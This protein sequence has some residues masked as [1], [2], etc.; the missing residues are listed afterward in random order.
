M[1][2]EPAFAPTWAEYDRILDLVGQTGRCR[3]FQQAATASGFI[4]IRHDVECS[5]DKAAEMAEHEYAHGI[6][7]TYCIQLASETYNPAT[8]HNKRIIYQ[9]ARQGHQIALHHRQQAQTP[10]QELEA[11]KTALRALSAIAGTTVNVYSFHQPKADTPYHELIIPGAI[12]T[13]AQPYFK[14]FGTDGPDVLYISDSRRQWNYGC[15]DAKTLAAHKRIQ[16]LIHP[17]GWSTDGTDTVPG[18][19]AAAQA[20]YTAELVETVPT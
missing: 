11:L 4:V 5:L 18:I 19:A 15:P 13:Y 14:R 2:R 20:R 12:N 7:T 17:F 16:L 8:E 10:A 9:I 3:T 6:K 1:T